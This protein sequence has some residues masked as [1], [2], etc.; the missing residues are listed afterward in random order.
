[1]AI[2]HLQCVRTGMKKRAGVPASAHRAEYT[3]QAKEF[4]SLWIDSVHDKETLEEARLDLEAKLARA[5]ADGYDEYESRLK[6]LDAEDDPRTGLHA[7]Y[8]P[9]WGW[10][11]V[12][13]ARGYPMPEESARKLASI[14]RVR[15]TELDA[16]RWL[17][18]AVKDYVESEDEDRVEEWDEIEKALRALEES[19]NEEK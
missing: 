15:G 12:V 6:R 19:S 9:G 10:G 2:R 17:H 16:L 11:L 4:C 18:G 7:S 14:L 13:N 8:K 5:Y 1:M 3:Q